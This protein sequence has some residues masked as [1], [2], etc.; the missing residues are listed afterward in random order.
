[1]VR[2]LTLV[3]LLLLGVAAAAASASAASDAPFVVTLKKVSLSRP[4]A[5]VERV[6]VSLDLYNQGSA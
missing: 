2:S 3:A 4:K 1:M 5:D 6:A